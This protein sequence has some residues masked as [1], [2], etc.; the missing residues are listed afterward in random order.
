[1]E[2]VSTSTLSI[3]AQFEVP[4]WQTVTVVKIPLTKPPASPLGPKLAV[5][6]AVLLTAVIVAVMLG[7]LLPQPA[8]TS[9]HI[10][11]SRKGAAMPME[12]NLEFNASPPRKHCSEQGRARRRFPGK[13][14]CDRNWNT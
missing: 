14:A 13:S 7:L 9:K 12:R 3:V 6:A 4:C 1:M 8:N 2:A 11:P 10:T 5:T